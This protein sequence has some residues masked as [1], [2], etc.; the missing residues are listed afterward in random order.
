MWSS[1]YGAGKSHVVLIILRGNDYQNPLLQMRKKR[2]RSLAKVT[3]KLRK[4][5]RRQSGDARAQERPDRQN[6]GS[7]NK[8]MARMDRPSPQKN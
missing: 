5:F 6:M 1:V 3:G 2:A 8:Q 4:I 7:S